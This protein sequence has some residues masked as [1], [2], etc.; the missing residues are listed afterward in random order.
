MWD[1]VPWLLT[2]LSV[3]TLLGI[4]FKFRPAFV[5]G[6]A[7]Q[8]VWLAFDWHVGARGLM[9]LAFVYGPLYVHGW[10]L[11]GRRR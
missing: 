1:Y 6:V 8:G 4:N 10:W 11:W 7:A 3:V 9:P 5:V 2:A